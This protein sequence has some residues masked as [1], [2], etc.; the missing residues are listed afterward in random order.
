MKASGFPEAF[1]WTAK[2]CFAASILLV[3]Y[4]P[5]AEWYLFTWN[6][7]L[8]FFDKLFQQESSNIKSVMDFRNISALIFEGGGGMF[9]QQLFRLV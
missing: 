9:G 3:F 2:G 5:H 7:Q 4:A 1:S 6:N 8:V